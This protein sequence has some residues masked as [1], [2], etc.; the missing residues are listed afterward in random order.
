MT[1]PP[2]VGTLLVGETVA[3]IVTE[4]VL[5]AGFSEDVSATAVETATVTD[6]GSLSLLSHV[7]NGPNEAMI[8]YVPGGSDIVV[9][10]SPSAF[11]SPGL[12]KLPSR[13]NETAGVKPASV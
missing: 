11:S 4:S 7:A 1:A 8:E 6:D 10:A 9:V 12:L 2:G 3:E 13:K 5:E